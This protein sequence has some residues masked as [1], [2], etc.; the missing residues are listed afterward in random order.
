MKWTMEHIEKLHSYGKILDYKVIGKGGFE[1]PKTEGKKSKY[2]NK[3]VVVGDLVFDSKKE[4]HRYQELSVMVLMGYI[5][6]LKLQVS[7][8][9]SV[10]RY[11]ADFTYMKDGAMVCE[12]VK[13]KIT[14]KN[15]AY[16]MK[17]KMMLAELGIE[18]IEV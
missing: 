6:D 1:L 15:R 3:K 13:S 14:K 4:Y 16:R 11:V 8:Q 2:G 7:F 18:I 9:L 5:T 10:C 12:D 17:K